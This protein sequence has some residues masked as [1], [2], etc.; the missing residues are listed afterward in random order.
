MLFGL[1]I[2]NNISRL[3]IIIDFFHFIFNFKL[4]IEIFEYF[5]I[6]KH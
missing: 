5:T 2:L 4:V 6:I 3:F 1:L